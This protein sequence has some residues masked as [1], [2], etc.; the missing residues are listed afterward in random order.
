MSFHDEYLIET[1]QICQV[2]DLNSKLKLMIVV[3]NKRKRIETLQKEYPGCLVIDVTSNSADADFLKFSPFYPHGGIPVP[4]MPGRTAACVEGIW[5]GLKTFEGEGIDTDT[6]NNRK[7]K[8][9]KR[10]TRTHGRCLG[11]QYEGKLIGYLTARHQIYLPAYQWVLENKLSELTR[12]LKRLSQTRTVVLLDY[13]TNGDVNDASKPL[14]HASL[15]KAFVD[16]MP[17]IL[18]EPQQPASVYAEGMKVRHAKFGE[19][20]VVRV[21]PEEGRVVVSFPEGEKTLSTRNAKLDVID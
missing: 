20:S 3:A 6:L 17:E 14:S 16:A 15:V 11:H 8:N 18:Q 13:E 19:G 1:V 21:I 10:T 9:I 2:S 4:G 7:M 12:R 5:Q